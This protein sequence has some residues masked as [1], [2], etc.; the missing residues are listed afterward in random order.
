MPQCSNH[1]E[2]QDTILLYMHLYCTVA[3]ELAIIIPYIVQLYHELL[4]CMG[5]VA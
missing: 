5:V 1:A 2:G 3:K 4:G